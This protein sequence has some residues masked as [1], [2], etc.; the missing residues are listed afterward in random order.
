M[1]QSQGSDAFFEDRFDARNRVIEA[2]QLDQHDRIRREQGEAGFVL[3]NLQ[4]AEGLPAQAVDLLNQIIPAVLNFSTRFG[5]RLRD[6]N[7]PVRFLNREAYEQ[8]TGNRLPS[9][10]TVEV[11]NE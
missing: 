5:I 1:A 9:A 3:Q 8:E 2:D 11:F 6:A 7:H 4:F 10:S